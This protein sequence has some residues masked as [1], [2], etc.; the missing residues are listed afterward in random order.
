MT[1][2]GMT[3]FSKLLHPSNVDSPMLVTLDGMTMFV[4]LLHPLNTRPLILV[5]LSGITILVK[6]LQ[7][8]NAEP[9]INR[10]A[11][12]YFNAFQI[13]TLCKCTHT[14]TCDARWYFYTC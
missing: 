1:L 12:R 3:I 4:K 8:S 13:T 2:D 7:L 11:R 5:I 10:Y 14:N 9:P 6:L